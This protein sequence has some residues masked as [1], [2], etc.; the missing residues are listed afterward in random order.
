MFTMLSPMSF[1]TYPEV[2]SV[3]ISHEEAL[4]KGYKA[5]IGSSPFKH[6]ENR[7]QLWIRRGLLKW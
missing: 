2:A 6:W 5:I 1:F 3:G 4:K 7:R